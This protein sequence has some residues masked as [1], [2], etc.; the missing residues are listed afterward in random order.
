[1]KKW[2]SALLCAGFIMGGSANAVPEKSC[3][4]KTVYEPMAPFAQLAGRAWRGEGTGPDG[5]P[6]VDIVKYEMILGGRAFQATHKLENDSYG[7][8]TIIFYDEGAAKYIFHYFTT[9]GFHTTGEIVPAETGFAAVEQVQSHLDYAEVRSE[10]VY[11]DKTIRVVST[12][13]DHDGKEAAGEERLY[14]EIPGQ[15]VLLFDEAGAL[16]GKRTD[17]KDAKDRHGGDDCN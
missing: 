9:A 5:K 12:L 1:M 13:L 14:T 2:I 16:F 8:R 6:I 3:A 11:G 7:G 4:A 10:A 17:V 15:T